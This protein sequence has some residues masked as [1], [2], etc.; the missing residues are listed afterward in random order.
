VVSAVVPRAQAKLSEAMSPLSTRFD[1]HAQF[2]I[3]IMVY[4]DTNINHMPGDIRK[5]VFNLGLYPKKKTILY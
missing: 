2:N 4:I 1:I 5:A 3:L